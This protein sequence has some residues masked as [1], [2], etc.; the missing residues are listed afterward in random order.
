MSK[1]YSCYSLTCRRNKT[2]ICHYGQISVMRTANTMKNRGKHFWGCS[3][4]KNGVQD[5]GC[6]FF[7]W[8]TDVGSEYSGRYV[9]SE[10][11]KETLVSS[12]ELEST[13]KMIV[14]IQKSMF[15][16]EKCMKGLILLVC[17]LCVKDDFSF[18]VSENGMIR[19]NLIC[20]NVI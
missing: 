16:L 4:Y 17:F 12:E 10:G 20:F 7:K 9:K 6:N 14:K 19:C 18:N 2:P 1:E 11:K 5:A 15:F 8:C 3:K 13:R